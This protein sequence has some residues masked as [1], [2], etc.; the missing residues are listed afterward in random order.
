MPQE[1]D[2]RVEGAGGR[3][4]EGGFERGGMPGDGAIAGVASACAAPG[5]AGQFFVGDFAEFCGDL[6]LVAHNAPFDYKFLLYL[7]LK[8]LIIPI[9]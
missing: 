6:P 1:D 2:R 3:D 4:G 5:D 8:L 9:R 7:E